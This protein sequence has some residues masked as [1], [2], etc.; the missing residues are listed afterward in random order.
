MKGHRVNRKDHRAV[1]EVRNNCLFPSVNQLSNPFFVLQNLGE[2]IACF[3][4]F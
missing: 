4:E 2:N 3:G 1:R